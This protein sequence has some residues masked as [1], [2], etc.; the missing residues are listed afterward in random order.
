MV[1]AMALFRRRRTRRFDTGHQG[2]DELL[3]MMASR[4]D[5]GRPRHWVHY[6]Y[7]AD[8]PAAQTA[9][10]RIGVQGWSLQRI[11]SA[12]Q[13]PGWVVIAEKH[14]AIVDAVSVPEARE[15]FED[16]AASLPGGDYDG[17]EATL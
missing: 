9:A 6:L 3:E 4:G 16:L 12:A 13:G 15:F 14:D 5:L 17:W 2:D 8:E 1:A 10:E 7:V 11:D